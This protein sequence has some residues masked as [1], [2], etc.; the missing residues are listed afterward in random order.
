MNTAFLVII[1]FVLGFFCCL[2][3][4]KWHIGNQI[5]EKLEEV[6]VIRNDLGQLRI[7]MQ[8]MVEKLRETQ[9]EKDKK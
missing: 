3:W 5:D 4:T 6:Q 2:V 8:E 1:S 7:K 9:K